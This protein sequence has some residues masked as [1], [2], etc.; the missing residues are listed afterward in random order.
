MYLT[1]EEIRNCVDE[2]DEEELVD[3]L[4]K[5]E[6]LACL[7]RAIVRNIVC[8]TGTSKIET[9]DTAISPFLTDCVMLVEQEEW[10]LAE[11]T[12][13]E[14]KNRTAFFCEMKDEFE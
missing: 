13:R 3:I 14:K 9:V 6:E 8:K 7:S 5:S 1:E 2:V 4:D 12:A 11:K 10:K